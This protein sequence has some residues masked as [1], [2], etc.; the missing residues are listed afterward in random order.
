MDL[1]AEAGSLPASIAGLTK[2]FKP[3]KRYNPFFQHRAGKSTEYDVEKG[4]EKYVDYLS[5]VLYHTDDIMRVR[6]AVKYFREEYGP[7]EI[8]AEISRAESL[9]FAPKEAKESFLKSAG[10]LTNTSDLSYA[11]LSA[12]M[13]EYVEGLFDSIKKTSKYSDLTVWLD[14]YANKLAGKQLF[15]DRD[16]EREV[17]RTSLNVGRKLNKMFARANVAGNLSSS[18]NQTAQ[19]P[20]IAG[21]IGP[22][23]V[24]KAVNDIIAGKTKGDFADQ[25]DFLTEKNGIDYLTN[26]KG[27]KITSALFWPLERMDYLISSIA[28][29][30]KYR[31]ELDAGRSPKEAMKAADRWARDIMGTRSKGAAPL[32]FQSKNLIAQMVNMF[33]VEA[34]N[35]WEHVT[36][37]LFGP[38]LKEAEAKLGKEEAA[39]RLAGIIVATL[40]GAFLL[41]RVAEEGYGGT[42]A[43]FDVIGLLVGFLASGN[44]LSTNEQIATW[45]DDAWENGTGERLFGT[46]A[47]AGNDEFDAG[48]ATEDTLYNV[49][50]D[51]PYLR[52][53]AGL[54]GLGDQTLPMPDIYG[55]VTGTAK[56]VKDNGPF[57]EEVMRQLMGLAGDTLPGG[58]QAEKTYQGIETLLKG[59]YYKGGGEDER[60]QY[61]VSDD[62]WNVVQATMF[63]RNALSETRDFYAAGGKG[64]SAAQ[65]RLYKQLVDMGADSE[66][67]YDAILA[68]KK[69]DGNEALSKAERET[70]RFELVQ[71]LPLTSEER[72]LLHNTLSGSDTKYSAADE[73][74]A[75][76]IPVGTYQ[77]FQADAAALESDRDKDGNVI[78]NSKK[79]KV[80]KLIDSLPLNKAQKNWLYLNEGYAESKLDETPWQ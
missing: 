14:D 7:D 58:R 63:G 50:N 26:D 57:S 8:S 16:M 52:N 51:I 77:K 11:D 19:L 73:A 9:R 10:L 74:K 17:G 47:N 69:I 42:P 13:E 6:A 22:K 5:D 39:K 18:L 53:A 76:G 31:K 55:T 65:T 33:Q 41:N 62:F 12:K 46:D 78:R 37:D 70:A 2:A 75:Q 43:Q 79:E 15:S 44:G 49:S 40:L 54:L 29:R 21:E 67:V 36:Q 45:I 23:Y 68:W 25:S 28:V 1:G 71:S 20:M 30:G 66:T 34:L 59:G 61:P 3:N 72:E 24:I 32:T 60:L 48:A 64:L 4:F 35:S 27:S 38:G 56:A 80:L